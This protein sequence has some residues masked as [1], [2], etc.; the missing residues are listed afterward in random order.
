MSK[1]N[2]ISALCFILAIQYTHIPHT[3]KNK[4]IKTKKLIIKIAL[5][6][7]GAVVPLSE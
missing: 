2:I 6:P 1:F 3:K 4:K 5:I 7:T